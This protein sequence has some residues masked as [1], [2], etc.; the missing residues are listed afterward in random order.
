[1][2]VRL[3]NQTIKTEKPITISSTASIVGT[4]E[5]EGPLSPYFDVHMED[6]EWGEDSWEKCESK[7]QREAAKL[8]VQKSG[9]TS[10]DIDIIFAGDLLNQCISSGFSARELRIPFYGLYGACSTMIE[11]IS[12]AAAIIDGG[13][14][15]KALAVASSHFCT[16]ERQ[17]RNPLEYGG[18]RTP[19]AQ[20]TVTGA[21]AAV[22]KCGMESGDGPYITHITTG[23]VVDFGITDTNNMGGAMAPAACDTLLAHFADT[24]RKPEDYDLI[25]TGDLGKVGREVLINL[26]ETEDYDMRNNYNDTG[27]MMFDFDKQ[28]VHAGGSGCGCVAATFCG[29]VYKMLKERKLNRVLI[30]GT[31]AL[32]SPTSSFQGESVP[33]IAHAIAISNEL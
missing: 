7:M 1:M 32:L 12:L 21:G 27:C 9:Y 30:V 28:D 26:L 2:A 5:S 29:Y 3:G 19:T 18:Q 16:A 6:A 10:D 11:G 20:W 14:A 15:D 25:L 13:G 17:Y 23:K 24:G 4:K 22:L 8:A 31:G 33:G